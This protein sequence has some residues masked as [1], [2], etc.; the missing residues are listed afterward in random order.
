[1]P[2]YFYSSLRQDITL[3]REFTF[4]LIEDL[5]QG[6]P[7]S[8]AR[9]VKVQDLKRAH[10]KYGARFEVVNIPDIAV[11]QFPEA[12]EGVSAVV[13]TASPLP[14][15]NSPADMLKGAIEGTLNVVRQAERAGIEKIVVT[16]SRATLGLNH[17]YTDQ[18][19]RPALVH[20]ILHAEV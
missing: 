5:S 14:T 19:R 18:G 15:R 1:M 7:V 10:T 9:G 6:R 20:A 12:L 11:D 3:E 13:H 8:A 4:P 16:S 17:D 2:T